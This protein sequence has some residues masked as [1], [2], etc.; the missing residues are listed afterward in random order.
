[1]AN[2]YADEENVIE[3]ISEPNI[4]PQ[5]RDRKVDWSKVE[6]FKHNMVSSKEQF[7]KH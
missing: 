2:N 6:K 7:K 5:M 3:E 1:M 4:T